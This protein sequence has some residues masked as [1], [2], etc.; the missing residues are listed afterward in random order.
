MLGHLQ[1]EELLGKQRDLLEK[2][3]AVEVQKAREC[4]KRNDKKGESVK[5]EVLRTRVTGMWSTDLLGRMDLLHVIAPQ[6]PLR[7]QL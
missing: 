2:K 6:S 5:W 3:M 7:A 4:M 1:Q